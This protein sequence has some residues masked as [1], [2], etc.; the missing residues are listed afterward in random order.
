MTLLLLIIASI[1][2][3]SQTSKHRI[4]SIK[5]SDFEVEFHDLY[6][7][8]DTLSIKLDSDTIEP[9]VEFGEM[10]QGKWIQITK[11]TL[12]D[13]RVEQSYV[14]SLSISNEGSHLDLL[15]WKHYTSEWCELKE[16]DGQKF[17][18]L[19]YSLDEDERF[20][21]FTEKELVNYLIR[22]KQSEYS[23]L[24]SNPNIG[25]GYKHWWTGISSIRIRI[26]GFNIENKLIT[27]YFIFEIPMGC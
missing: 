18:I 13:I 4:S 19:H 7:S 26:S 14:T 22:I 27:K 20:P 2:S 6:I 10:I 12:K 24:I 15:N 5:L 25:D 23:E 3:N 9:L 17:K 8:E 16:I 11:S 21:K 1:D